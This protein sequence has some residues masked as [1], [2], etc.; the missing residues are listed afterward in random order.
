MKIYNF[1]LNIPA[2][3]VKLYYSGDRKFVHVTGKMGQ[4]IQFPANQIRQ[5]VTNNGVHGEFEIIVDE[6]NR[7]IDIRQV[8]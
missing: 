6:N 5:F 8:E 4:S 1:S 3:E 2:E 7:L